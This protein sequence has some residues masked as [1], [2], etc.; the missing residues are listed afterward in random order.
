MRNK[1]AETLARCFL[2]LNVNQQIEMLKKIKRIFDREIKIDVKSNF[3]W[4][5]KHSF[6][7]FVNFINEYPDQ[8]LGVYK[9]LQ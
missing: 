9:I 7:V 1:A 5:V 6:M 2:A 3:T 4:E 8:Q